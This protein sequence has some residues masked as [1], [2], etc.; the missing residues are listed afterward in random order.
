MPA[1]S[2]CVLHGREGDLGVNDPAPCEVVAELDGDPLKV[3]QPRQALARRRVLAEEVVEGPE[4]PGGLA[5]SEGVGLAVAVGELGDRVGADAAF[6][7]D[8]KVGFRQRPQ[9]RRHGW[10]AWARMSARC[11]R[12]AAS[13]VTVTVPMAASASEM[14]S[15]PA[16][17][18]PWANR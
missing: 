16:W 9:I 10:H 4:R 17:S 11:S 2:A 6:E 13:S 1:Q 18:R 12:P 8:V 3:I 5:G 15:T 14:L 7:V